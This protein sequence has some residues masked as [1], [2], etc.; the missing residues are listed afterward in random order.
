MILQTVSKQKL[1]LTIPGFRSFFTPQ[2]VC[3]IIRK[4][5]NIIS[6]IFLVYFFMIKKADIILFFIILVLGIAVSVAS[7]SGQVQGDTVVVTVDGELYGEYPLNVD[8]EVIIENGDH[9]NNIT[10]KNGTCQMKSSTCDNQVC[11]HTGEIRTTGK[12]IVC[13]P[14]RVMVEIVSKT[15]GGPDVISS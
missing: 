5:V 10:I 15:G 7:L 6:K 3:A 1:S 9:I 11:V 2:L 4:I 14:N 8:R 13:L 12:Q